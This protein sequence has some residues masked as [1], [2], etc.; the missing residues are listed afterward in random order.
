MWTEIIKKLKHKDL[1]QK[2]I[3]RIPYSNILTANELATEIQN[4]A[5]RIASDFYDLKKRGDK[6]QLTKKFPNKH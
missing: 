1:D 6:S 4:L 2:Q 3:E 5:K